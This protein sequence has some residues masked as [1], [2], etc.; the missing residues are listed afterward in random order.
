MGE[1][2]NLDQAA[3][4]V[5]PPCFWADL[6]KLGVTPCLM[7]LRRKMPS[8]GD[9]IDNSRHDTLGVESTTAVAS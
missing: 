3:G 2:K 4:C 1:P 9:E 8:K 6:P 7:D 5:A